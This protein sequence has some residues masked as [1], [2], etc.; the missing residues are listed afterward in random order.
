MKFSQLS[1]GQH[2]NYKQSSYVKNS[3]LIAVDSKTGKNRFF[4]L[5]ETVTLTDSVPADN[6]DQRSDLMLPSDD[7]LT[8]FDESLA[9]LK[10]QLADTDLDTQKIIDTCR[11]SFLNRLKQ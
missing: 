10:I 7:V 8:A 2:F 1:A 5:S 9:T 4:K 3:A 6:T 11:E